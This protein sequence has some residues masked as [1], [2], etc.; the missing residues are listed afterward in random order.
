MFSIIINKVNNFDKSVSLY[1]TDKI[2]FEI[3]LLCQENYQK[4]DNLFF[5]ITI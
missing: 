5:N 2:Y 1:N 4:W 3:I